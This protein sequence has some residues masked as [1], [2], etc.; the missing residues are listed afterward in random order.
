MHDVRFG[1][2][3]SV[4]LLGCHDDGGT[5]SEFIENSIFIERF[6][7]FKSHSSSWVYY[8]HICLQYVNHQTSFKNMLNI[9]RILTFF[10]YLQNRQ[11]EE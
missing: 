1:N 7:H 5:P 3:I 11:V 4:A 9:E 2:M 6:Y 8:S 10:Y